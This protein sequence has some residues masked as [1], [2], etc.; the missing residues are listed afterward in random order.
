MLL[1]KTAEFLSAFGETGCLDRPK[2]R[3]ARSPNI[4]ADL[5]YSL[6]A[7]ATQFKLIG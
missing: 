2:T 5:L 7:I 3:K 4:A 1:N 6:R